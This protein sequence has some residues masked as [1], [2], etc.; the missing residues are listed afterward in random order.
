MVP[1]K[2]GLIVTISSSGGISHFFSVAYCVGKTACDRMAADMA[3]NLADSNVCSISLWPGAVKTEL[4]MQVAPDAMRKHFEAG[5]TIEFSGKC[6]VA[7]ATDPKLME[8]TGH[9]LN[10]MDLAK[11]YN[12]FDEDGSQPHSELITK[13]RKY[14]DATNKV[15]APQT[16]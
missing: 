6:V 10:T 14:L 15:R 4:I 11:E 2:K 12:L 7:L 9:I 13:H 16:H 8:K 5:E 3:H 1:K